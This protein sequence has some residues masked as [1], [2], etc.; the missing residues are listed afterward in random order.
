MNNEYTPETAPLT[1]L[2]I[3]RKLKKATQFYRNL[4]LG[5]AA[6]R[7]FSDATEIDFLTTKE[8]AVTWLHEVVFKQFWN[9]EDDTVEL[10]IAGASHPFVF[11]MVNSAPTVITTAAP[12][13]DQQVYLDDVERTW[14]SSWQEGPQMMAF[15]SFKGGVGRTTSLM[16]FATAFVHESQAPESNGPKKLLLIDGDFEAP[17]ISF[18]LDP[19]NRPEI[20]LVQLLEALHYPPQDVP[21]TL[22]FFAAQLRKT[23]LEMPAGCEIF[24]LPAA[25]DLAEIMDMPVRPEH[26]ARNH[27]NPWCLSDH[28]QQLGKILNADLVMIDLRAGLSELASPILFDPRIEHYFVSTIATQSI[29]GME[30]IL[31][32][33]RTFQSKFPNVEASKP[34]IILSLL[35]EDLRKLPEYEEALEKL[36]AAFPCPDPDKLEAGIDWLEANFDSNLM[37]LRGIR[38]AFELL[39]RSSLFPAAAKW[40][41]TKTAK[42]TTIAI[43]AQQPQAGA[44]KMLFE[45]C[46]TFQ[47]AETAN[48]GDMLMTEPLRNLA[49]HF[50]QELPNVVSVGAKGAGKTFVFVQLCNCQNWQSFLRKAGGNPEET[51]SNAIFPAM[52]STNLAG[53][54]NDIVQT[55]RAQ[56][57]M[58]LGLNSIRDQVGQQIKQALKKPDCDWDATW[59][60][61]LLAPFA[62]LV[63]PCKNFEQ[64]NIALATKGQ[65]LVLIVDGIED[66]F[67]TPENEHQREAI[68]ALLQIPNRLNSM[69][70]RKIGFICLVREDFIQIAMR[71]NLQQYLA[72]FEAFKLEWTSETFLRLVYWICAKAGV[73]AAT[74]EQASTLGITQLLVALE[75]LWGKKLGNDAAREANSA[76]WVFSALC[77]YNGRL[78]ARDIVRFLK[79]AAQLSQDGSSS[80]SANRVL[81]PDAMRKALTPCSSEKVKEALIEIKPLRD[82]AHQLESIRPEAKT[83]PFGMEA[84][85]LDTTVLR[86]LQDL[87][88]IY[89]N[90][91]QAMTSERYYLP[92]IYRIGMGFT[93]LAAGRPKILA[94]LKR[95]L[96]SLPF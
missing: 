77:D 90:K 23:S 56:C 8:V 87:G 66:Y 10:A 24:I 82:W 96:G 16:T 29:F 92:E 61:I 15:H 81:T 95:N 27:T 91:D 60:D 26:L 89:E 25:L 70:N 57:L 63:P 72:R 55:A 74:P 69:R 3:E 54:Q 11:E 65:S 47:F 75:A 31:R 85:N 17:G 33:L 79:F 44:A 14:P 78:Q 22:A 36:N 86:N 58:Q 43:S 94:F 84:V 76:R 51:Q 41:E 40:A 19:K 50:S 48:T 28:L 62:E 88:V 46:K 42:V 73:I 5:I 93:P 52:A 7:C 34:S 53:Q 18:W 71:Q 2:D 6:I 9:L 1:W 49:K 45:T 68:K 30:Q 35:T 20:S 80:A 64:L 83:V 13:W 4:P 59:E 38:Q 21:S 37:S 12:L 32:R 67:D 39:P